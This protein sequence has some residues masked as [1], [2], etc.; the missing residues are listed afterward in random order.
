M[1]RNLFRNIPNS[2][3]DELV[4]VLAVGNQVRV[5][6]IVSTGHSSEHDFWYD[7][8]EH[9]WILVLTGE[10]RLQIQGEDEPLRMVPGDYILIP[11]HR[12]HRVEWTTP[13]EPTVWLAVFYGPAA[14]NQVHDTQ[15]TF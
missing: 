5:E 13:N 2:L 7:Q 6:R 12:K 14:Q 10:A 8:D 3:S 11:A 15:P 4:E 1:I 9:E